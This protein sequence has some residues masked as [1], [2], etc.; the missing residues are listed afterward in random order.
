MLKPKLRRRANTPGLVQ[1]RE[2]S[3]TKVTWRLEWEMVSLPQ[4][5]RMASAARVAVTAA[6]EM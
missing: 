4:C 1:I 6:F 5:P 2:R 3:S